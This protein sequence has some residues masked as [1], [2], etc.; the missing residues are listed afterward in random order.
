MSYFGVGCKE[1]W[2]RYVVP[3]VA[4]AWRWARDLVLMRRRRD[5]GRTDRAATVAERSRRVAS[6]QR[7][8]E[9]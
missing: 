2:N 3:P 9:Q 1:S 4:S 8:H 5:A 6:W 7:S